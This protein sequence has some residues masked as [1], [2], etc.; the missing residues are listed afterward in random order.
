MITIKNLLN[1]PQMIGGK[2]LGV[3]GEL[4][5]RTVTDEMRRLEAKKF[6][7]I[8]EPAKPEPKGGENK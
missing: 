7:S 2:S 8:V 3:D 6:I 1:N 4:A 5:V